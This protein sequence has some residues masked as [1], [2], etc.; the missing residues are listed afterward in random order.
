MEKQ[1]KEWT[2]PEDAV[3]DDPPKKRNILSYLNPKN[4]GVDDFSSEPNFDSAFKKAREKKVEEFVYGNER[5]AVKVHPLYDASDSPDFNTA[6]RTAYDKKEPQFKYKDKVYKTELVSKDTE[7]D[8]KN[9]K[10]F[11][12]EYVKKQPFSLS[13]EDSAKANP[14]KV[15]GWDKSMYGRKQDE[16]RQKSTS[17][18]NDK[19]YTSITEQK[20]N[21]EKDGYYRDS[22]ESYLKKLFIS[23][24]PDNP[25]LGGVAVHELAHKAGLTA[26]EPLRNSKVK[27]NYLKDPGER[28]AR[29]ISTLYYLDKIGHKFDK[30]GEKE[31]K[32]L[33]EAEE[34]L[35]Y[36]IYQLMEV[37]GGKDEF[38]RQMNIPLGYKSIL[39]SDSKSFKQGDVV[40]FDDFLKIN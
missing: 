6:F 19:I 15:K 22:D 3:T 16:A 10:R 11:V 1:T 30:F 35:P 12:G 8:Y 20:G 34:N 33:Q 17:Q 7:E 18:F 28:A 5:Y 2:P 13:P 27:D 24:D 4:W 9:A 14:F 39:K 40:D 29:H 36:D 38:I 32:L 37:Y 23:T 26:N 31:Y 25:D 21:F